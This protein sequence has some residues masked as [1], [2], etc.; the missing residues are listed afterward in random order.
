MSNVFITTL[1]AVNIDGTTTLDIMEVHTTF[2]DA[3]ESIREEMVQVKN[4][5]GLEQV[6][7]HTLASARGNKLIYAVECRELHP[8]RANGETSCK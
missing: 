1:L 5:F 6:D 7:R 3:M 4:A 2:T 8:Q